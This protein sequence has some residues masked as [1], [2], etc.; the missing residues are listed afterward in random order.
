[1]LSAAQ[2]IAKLWGLGEHRWKLYADQR[3]VY[4][5]VRS[6]LDDPATQYESYY[7]DIARQWGKTFMCVLISDEYARR[8]PGSQIRY[9][10]TTGKALRK[11]VHPNMRALLTDCPEHLRPTWNGQDS[12]YHYANGSEIHM[13]GANNGHADDSR[14]QRAHLIVIEEAGFVD[15]LEYLVSSVLTPQLTTTGGRVLFIT[16]PPETPAHDVTKYRARCEAKGNYIL[17]DI[18]QNRH[19]TERAKEKLIEECGGRDSP[20]AQRELWCKWMV[21]TKRAIVPEFGEHKAHVVVAPTVPEHFFP[22]EAMDVGFKHLHA[23]GYGWWDFKRAKLVLWDESYLRRARTDQIAAAIHEKEAEH[24]PWLAQEMLRDPGRGWA[25]EPW[26]ELRWPISRWSDVDLRLIEDLNVLHKLP[27][28]PTA[29]DDLE[30]QINALRILVKEHK[31]EIH[32][33]CATTIAHL[34][35]GIWNKSRTNFEE[36]EE[37]GHFDGCAMMVYML[38]NALRNKDPFPPTIHPHD[39]MVVRTEEAQRSE[40]LKRAFFNEEA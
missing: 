18:D 17:R 35:Y 5:A 8:N 31:L 13:A 6:F 34:E 25:H 11:L 28:Q 21:N 15:D 29:K 19:L 7:V 37:F 27:F 2:R 10:S 30:A 20:Q 26:R 14:G 38:R 9:V 4:D 22:L 33:R 39:V 32:P 1:M 12:S 23:I 3:E 40:A 24:W 36:T 16:T